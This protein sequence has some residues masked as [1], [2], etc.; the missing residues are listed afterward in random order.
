MRV[1]FYATLRAVV[2]QKTVDLPIPDGSC[3]IDVA[4]YVATNWPALADQLLD[5]TGEVSNQV[6]LLIGGRNIR[7]LPDG[8]ATAICA[9]DIVDI[10][11]PTAGG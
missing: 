3:A 2:G 4:R 1:N 6:Q 8:S 10:F 11:P 9:D 5:S 7:W